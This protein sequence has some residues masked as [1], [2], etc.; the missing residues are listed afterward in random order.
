VPGT[1]FGFHDKHGCDYPTFFRKRYRATA[2]FVDSLG[3]VDDRR[4]DELY[5]AFV[6]S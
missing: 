1:F 4:L 5:R 2:A 6:N 3:F